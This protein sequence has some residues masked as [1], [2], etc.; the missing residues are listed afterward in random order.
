MESVQIR[1]THQLI[2]GIDGLVKKG[3]YANRNEAIRDAVRRLT[4]EYGALAKTG[5][6]RANLTPKSPSKSGEKLIEDVRREGD[7]V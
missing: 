2:G 1:L 6:L 4:F 7:W 5:R 3:I